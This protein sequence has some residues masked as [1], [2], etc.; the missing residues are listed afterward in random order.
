MDFQLG[1]WMHGYELANS[2]RA[3]HIVEGLGPETHAAYCRDALAAV[4]R[5]C[6]AISAVALR[7]HGESGIKE[8]SYEFWQ[9][10]FDGVK[11]SGRRVE[12]DLH[13][14]GLDQTMIE[15][16]LATGMPVNVSPKYWAEHL[17]MPYHQAAIRDLEMPVEGQTG[18]GLM[19]L[20]EGSLSYT[21]YGYADF[22]R[23]DRKYT[24]RHRVFA[25][26]QRLLLAADPA[27]TAAYS[28][29]FS[30]CGIDR[31]RPDGAAHVPRTARDRHSRDAARRLC[32]RPTRHAVGLGEV[33]VLVPRVGT[34]DLRRRL[35]RGTGIALALAPT[36]RGRALSG[37]LASASRILPTVTT[38]HLPSAACDAYWPEIY[39]N[40]PIVGEPRP[41]P[42]GDTPAPKVFAHVSPLD[43]ELFSSIA[44]H[45]G[46]LLD[47]D[48]RRASTRRS[49]RP[50]GSKRWRRMSIG[51][52]RPPA[53]RPHPAIAGS[54]SMRGSRRG[55]DASSPRSSAPACCMRSTNRPATARR[56]TP[57]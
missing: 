46:E 51:I 37:A 44:Q 34:A 42:Y 21:R 45:A 9:T 55:S 29:M 1:V 27:A 3:R 57:R 36:P 12:I 35:R 40:Q 54:R 25:G 13:A 7:I 43:P 39:W 31:R 16:A 5:A 20:S 56:S 41:N 18:R 11:R 8:G 32:R 14:K 19:T 33:R 24:V 4:L 26:T 48:H 22:L 28:R 52:S 49:R 30:F 10:V 6:P 17:G 2:P 47:G 53:E 38:A 50:P 23:D 15:R